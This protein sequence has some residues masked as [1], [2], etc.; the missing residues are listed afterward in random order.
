MRLA[1]G[2]GIGQC[3]LIN[4]IIIIVV[5]ITVANS[6]TSMWLKNQIFLLRRSSL[7]GLHLAPVPTLPMQWGY[8]K[9]CWS[10]NDQTLNNYIDRA[11]SL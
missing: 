4:F 2:E 10:Q 11:M 1:G 5:V 6:T 8:L 3:S 7:R 9:M